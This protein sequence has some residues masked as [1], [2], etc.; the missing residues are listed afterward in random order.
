M[1]DALI[2]NTPFG[3][4]RI[5]RAILETNKCLVEKER[6]ESRMQMVPVNYFS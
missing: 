1:L 3:H 2:T 6:N 5:A 4:N